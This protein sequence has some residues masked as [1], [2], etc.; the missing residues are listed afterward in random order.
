[1]CSIGVEHLKGKST[2]EAERVLYAAHTVFSASQW[3]WNCA[4]KGTSGNITEKEK[5]LCSFQLAGMREQGKHA[6][7][8]IIGWRLK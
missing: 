1:M 5:Q 7:H 8:I 4:D 3:F 6:A 2:Q